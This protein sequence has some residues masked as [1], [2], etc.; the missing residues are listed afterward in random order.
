M[1]NKHLLI[2]TDIGTDV[3]DAIALLQILGS[4]DNSIISVTTVYGNVQL[5]AQIAESYCS[6]QET[7]VSIFP[8]SSETLSGK[9][10]WMSG[11]E[12]SLHKDLD[13]NREFTTSAK[14]HLSNLL[15]A[16]HEIN[17]FAIAPLTNLARAIDNESTFDKRIQN[18]FLMGGRFTEGKAEHNIFSDI[19]AAQRVFASDLKISVVGIE[20]TSQV[21]IGLDSLDRIR[22]CGE[23][24]L[25]LV[26][27]II[28]WANFRGQHWIMPHDSIAYLMYRKPEIFEFSPWG[29]VSI[30]D[31]GKTTFEID[32]KGSHRYVT[33]ID[34]SAAKEAIIAGVEGVKFRS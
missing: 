11:L 1:L 17:I 2:D 29:Q 5:R 7:P 27:E 22:N 20:I 13:T 6:L 31:D 9:D 34:V 23:S 18:V 21:K 4:V 8:G 12:G 14:K 32:A 30:S 26:S 28:Q 25:L 24:G 10:I 15:N 3:D 16:P 19:T 33:N